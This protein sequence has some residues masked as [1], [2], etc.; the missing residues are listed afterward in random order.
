M[1]LNTDLS[2]DFGALAFDDTATRPQSRFL[3]N[4]V[5]S[6]P[7]LGYSSRGSSFR[8]AWDGDQTPGSHRLGLAV[9]DDQEEHGLESNSVLYESSMERE[10][11]RLGFQLGA[12]MED[13]SLLG[14][15]SD[16]AFSANQTDTYY[17]GLNG[18]WQL[19]PDVTLM[20]GYFQ[21][22]SRVQADPNSLLDQFSDIR[23]EGYGL[24][25]LVESVFSSRDSIGLA[26]SSPMQTT[27]GSAR[28][29]LPVSQNPTTGEIGFESSTLSFEGASQENIFEAY[30]AYDLGARGDVFAHVSYTSNPVVDTE[31]SRDRTIYLGWKHD[32]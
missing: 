14:G 25:L 26:W 5:F 3:H 9:I 27:G 1:A 22:M 4:Q 7:V 12:L 20:G 10:S 15:A 21:G 8:F 32:F 23:T 31:L 6:T 18:A 16:G 17:L 11:Y 2:G 28:L 13:G 19:G 30:Y 24:G 29:T